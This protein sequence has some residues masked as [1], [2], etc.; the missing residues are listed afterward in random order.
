M[1]TRKQY[2]G[3]CQCCGRRQAV[4][5]SGFMAKH[6][7]TVDNGW[8]KGICSGQHFQPM[9]NNRVVTDSIISQVRA[10]CSEL[11][12]TVRAYKDGKAH[13]ARITKTSYKRG[14]DSTMAWEDAAEW[15]QVS[16]LRT[17]IMQLEGRARR[18]LGFA[19]TLETLVNEVNGKPLYEVEVEKGPAP[20]QY[21]ESRKAPSGKILKVVRL[22]GQRVYWKDER[23]F[24]SWTGASAWRKYELV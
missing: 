12:A 19:D 8:F 23:G 24:G 9:Q 7:Y 20:I 4:L 13:P 1:D 17:A 5:D 3:N 22:E 21:G 18:G 14:E 6:G 16:G 2:R 15:Q 10:D 11:L